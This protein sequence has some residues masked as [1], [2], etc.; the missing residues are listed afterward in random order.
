MYMY[1]YVYIYIY[2]YI[3][4]HVCMYVCRHWL[5]LVCAI[6]SSAMKKTSRQHPENMDITI[7]S[8][9]LRLLLRFM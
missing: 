3:Y 9:L 4:K 5:L 7:L 1:M 6:Y 2:I 8:I